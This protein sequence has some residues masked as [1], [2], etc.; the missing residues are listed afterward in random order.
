MSKMVML[1]GY[2]GRYA[3]TDDGRIWSYPKALTI[4]NRTGH[5]KGR[6]LSPQLNAGGYL[7]VRLYDGKGGGVTRE[8]RRLVLQTF[9]GPCPN[10][11]ECCHN[12]GIRTDN[13]VKNLRWDTRKSNIADSVRQGTHYAFPAGRESPNAKFTDTEVGWIR[14]LSQNTDMLWRDIA[15]IFGCSIS[16]VNFVKHQRESKTTGEL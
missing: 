16:Y 10:G 3:I 1:P 4:R 5:T 12:N 8:V 2:E 13:R 15:D 9:V 6:W 7:R 14:W 11:M